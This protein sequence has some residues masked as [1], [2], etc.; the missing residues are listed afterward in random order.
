MPIPTLTRRAALLGLVLATLSG[1]ASAAPAVAV[2]GAWARSTVAGQPAGGGFLTL[3]N[4]GGADR[5]TA[6]SSPAAA[7]VELHE[8]AMDGDVMRM[9]QVEGIALPAGGTVE[10]KPGGLHLMFMGLKAPLK[11]GNKVPL[12][13][14]FEKAGELTVQVEV[15]GATAMPK[16]HDHAGHGGHKH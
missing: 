15:R 5:L 11:A 16:A 6:A 1:T 7:S 8:M 10:L 14:R 12:T 13:L 2:E 9:R 3:R 4:G